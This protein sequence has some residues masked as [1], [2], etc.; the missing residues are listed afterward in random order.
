RRLCRHRPVA[1]VP[2][3]HGEAPAGASTRRLVGGRDPN[4]GPSKTI[5]CDKTPRTTNAGSSRRVPAVVILGAWERESARPSGK[6]REESLMF[7]SFARL[8]RDLVP[9]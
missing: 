6:V 7:A 4:P 3:H 1:R 8:A 2:T 5:F 9:V